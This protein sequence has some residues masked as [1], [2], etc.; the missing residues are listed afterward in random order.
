MA[1]KFSTKWAY[2]AVVLAWAASSGFAS[3]E[4]FDESGK[5]VP[6]A[7]L[8]HSMWRPAP[9]AANEE[10]VFLERSMKPYRLYEG[11]YTTIKVMNPRIVDVAAKTDSTVELY[12]QQVGGETDVIF[13]DENKKTLRILHV[14]VKHPVDILFEG[15]V[16]D[17]RSTYYC[18]LHS[19]QF[20]SATHYSYP[21]QVVRSIQEGNY[22]IQIR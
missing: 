20:L 19:C 21:E 9:L 7:Q 12:P 22:N 4:V 8:R 6:Y 17:N 14:E 10:I 13:L 5:P 2:A 16:K 15:G 18:S 11:P 3:A 1:S